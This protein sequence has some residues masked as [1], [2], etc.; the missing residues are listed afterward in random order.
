[1]TPP[2]QRSSNSD[3]ETYIADVLPS[4]QEA[5]QPYFDWIFGSS[6]GATWDVAKRTG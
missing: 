2:L 6:A 5:G 4:L 1:M 3:L